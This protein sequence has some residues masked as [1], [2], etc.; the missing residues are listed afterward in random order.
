MDFNGKKGLGIESKF[1]ILFYAA[2]ISSLKN[3]IYLINVLRFLIRDGYDPALVLAGRDQ[4]GGRFLRK[5]IRAEMQ[6]RVKLVGFRTDLSS[7]IHIADFCTPSS[8]REGLGLNVVEAMAAGIPVIA[9]NNRGHRQSIIDGKNG[10][11]VSKKEPENMA[12]MIEKVAADTALRN[13]L[14]S[15]AKK[16]CLNFDF[17]NVLGKIIQIYIDSVS[18]YKT[19]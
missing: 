18:R 14:V 11:L 2:E 13:H 15:E 9:V 4:T 17:S 5:V 7:F 6:D 19:E 12:L 8:T 10:Y 3:Q 1:P 16:T